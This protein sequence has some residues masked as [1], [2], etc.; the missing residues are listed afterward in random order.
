MSTIRLTCGFTP[1]DGNKSTELTT[2]GIQT[3]EFGD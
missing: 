1:E 2:V 3:T